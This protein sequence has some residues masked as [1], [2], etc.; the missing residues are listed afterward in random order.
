MF[1]AAREDSFKVKLFNPAV[2]DSSAVNTDRMLAREDEIWDQT[3]WH[4]WSKHRC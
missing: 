2:V 4:S 3:L 1:S